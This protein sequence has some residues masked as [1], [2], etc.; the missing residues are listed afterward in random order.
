M[1]VQANM[2]VLPEDRKEGKNA[3]RE[4]KLFCL[5]S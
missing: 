5:S 1:T 3:R 4:C 2:V